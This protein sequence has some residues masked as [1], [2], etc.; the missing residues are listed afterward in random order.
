MHKLRDDKLNKMVYC[1][2]KILTQYTVDVVTSFSGF[3]QF[4]K[5]V[6]KTSHP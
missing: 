5:L 6:S 3:P 2:E 4:K 1:V